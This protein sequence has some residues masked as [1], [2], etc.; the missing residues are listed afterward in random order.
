MLLVSQFIQAFF[1]IHM[2]VSEDLELQA[3]N[4]RHYILNLNPTIAN[5][6]I[7]KASQIG[8]ICNLNTSFTI[9]YL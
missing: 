9:K 1:A 7:T 6:Q 5:D 2:W 8:Y 3:Y 4:V